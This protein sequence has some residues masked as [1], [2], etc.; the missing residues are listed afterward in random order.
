MIIGLKTK[1]A[2]TILTGCALS[3]INLFAQDP[4]PAES[5]QAQSEAYSE[6]V[7][8][9]DPLFEYVVAPEDM[10]SLQERSDYLMEHFWDPMDL[11]KQEAVDQT[12]LN[13]AFKVYTTPM[14]WA[15]REITHKSVD[16]L[17]KQLKK[18]P[19]LLYQFTRAAEENLYGPRARAWV[20]EIYVKFLESLEKNKKISE[21]RKTRFRSQLSRIKN[22]MIGE[23]APEFKFIKA[24][25][26]EGLYFPMSTFTIIEI[27]DPDC[28]ECTMA[29]LK[30]ESNVALD[31]LVAKGKVNILFMIPTDEED[32]KNQTSDYPSR[33]TIGAA[34]DIDEVLDIR[35]T[36]SFYTVGSDGKI[37][38]KNISVERAIMEAIEQNP[39]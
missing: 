28:M 6:D 24:D 39:E 11:S 30:M 5:A 22:S 36:P 37:I 14:Q 2:T 33:W 15:S 3:A 25:G 1:I 8:V 18:N 19:V 12:A 7:I 4:A 34:P 21:S 29:R 23:R 17:L 16:K 31:K 32:W 9:I 27:G 26:S 38:S 35:S 20:D 10:K 13:A